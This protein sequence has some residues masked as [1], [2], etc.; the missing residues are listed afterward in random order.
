MKIIDPVHLH[1]RTPIRL[2]AN[3]PYF[4]IIRRNKLNR[5]YLRKN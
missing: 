5:L 2:F 3:N 1:F 4:Q